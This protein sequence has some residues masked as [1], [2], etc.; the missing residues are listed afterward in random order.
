MAGIN[1]PT[2]RISDP[3][4]RINDPTLPSLQAHVK[5]FIQGCRLP[6]LTIS[7]ATKHHAKLPSTERREELEKR[8]LAMP[9]WKRQA[10]QIL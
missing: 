4:F 6:Y 8:G 3:T 2:L 9:L 7:V 5:Q 1:D 10:G